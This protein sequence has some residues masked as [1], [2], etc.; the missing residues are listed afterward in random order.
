MMTPEH[1]LKL[2]LAREAAILRK[3]GQ[4]VSV[5]TFNEFKGDIQDKMDKILGILEKNAAPSMLI[6]P[7]AQ[8][9]PPLAPP[10][11]NSTG[12]P[13]PP[14]YN[15]IVSVEQSATNSPLQNA[16]PPSSYMKIVN[17]FFDPS[18]GFNAIM[19]FPE[20]NE[21]GMETGGMT[22]TIE[23]PLKFSNASPAHL[24][25]YKRDLRSVMLKP[26]AIASGIRE[27]CSKVAKNLHYDK[28]V[29]TKT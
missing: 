8:I 26:G 12:T 24:N 9:L 18:D 21:L 7:P 3:N 5:D 4:F 20:L 29:Q 19:N 22:F 16:T 6:V 25:Y 11:P 2:K 13:M 28:K 27:W 15:Q 10:N 23:V 14:S 1:K 17:E